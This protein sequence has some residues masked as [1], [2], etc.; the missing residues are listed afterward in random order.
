[1]ASLTRWT[2]IWVN[3]G[4][5]WWTGRPG[6]LRF[7]WLQGVG[8][9]WVNERNWT[10]NYK[11]KAKKDIITEINFVKGLSNNALIYIFGYMVKDTDFCPNSTLLPCRGRTHWVWRCNAQKSKLKGIRKKHIIHKEGHMNNIMVKYWTLLICPRG[12]Y[13]LYM[14]KGEGRRG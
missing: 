1:M 13:G 5:W 14:W 9:N 10:S 8:H 6:V 2:W 4:S 3:S 7:M 11:T 12:D